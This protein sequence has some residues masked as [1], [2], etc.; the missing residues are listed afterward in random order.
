MDY[1]KVDSPTRIK[2]SFGLIG[3]GWNAAIPMGYD[4]NCGAANTGFHA[5]ENHALPPG[6]AGRDQDFGGQH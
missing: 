6:H 1:R 4:V 3:T 2:N 5:V